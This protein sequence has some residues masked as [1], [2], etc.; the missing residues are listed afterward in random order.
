MDGLGP[1]SL[2]ELAFLRDA[3]WSPDG[4]RVAYVVSRT[5]G[6]AEV[7]E[8]W[9]AAADGGDARCVPAGGD[10]ATPR[11]SPDGRELAISAD[12]RLHIV[13]AATL[14]VSPPMTPADEQMTGAPS[15]SPDGTR[16]AVS[17][18][19]HAR[20]TSSQGIT[21]YDY[22]AEGLGL[23]GRLDRAI[24]EVRRSDGATRRLTAPELG[25]CS[26][27][28]WSPDGERVL[29]FATH[30]AVP[31]ASD[32]PRLLTVDIADGATTEVLAG[33]WFVTAARWLDG[34]RIVVIGEHASRLTIPYTRLWVV[35]RTGVDV[36][37][38]SSGVRGKF[39]MHVH[40]DMPAWDLTGEGLVVA[41]EHTAYATVQNG[42]SAEVW[43]IAL[44]G[45][46]DARPVLSGE[47]SCIVLD[48]R[49]GALLYAVT[50]LRTPPELRSSGPDGGNEH[51]L[52]GLNDAVLECWPEVSIDRMVFTSGDGL[53]IEG[54]RLAPR[55]DRPP[56]GVLFIHGGPFAATGHA[57][58]FDFLLLASHGLAVVFANFRGSAGYGEAH[59]RG[60]MGDWGANG[61][62]DHMA[63]ADAAVARGWVDP[64]RLGVW[65]ASHGG[66]ATCWMVTH[67]HRFR[68]AVA[69]AS[70]TDFASLYYLT[71]APRTFV[72]DLGG[73]PHEIPDVYRS[74]SP[75]SYAQSCRTPTM[76]IHGEA[77]LRCPIEQAEKFYRALLDARCEAELVRIPGCDH[78]GDS[79]GPL[80]AR[81]AQNEA[82]LRWF[83]ERL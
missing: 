16:L 42:G 66:F 45:D 47:R 35:D 8:V 26:G 56:P 68:A 69:E 32:S 2:F 48:V 18:S 81:L 72:A 19:R 9:T 3:R 43:R 82:L 80:S 6:D 58:R 73:R 38:R 70:V 17:L 67:T 22:R 61:F 29:F 39:G 13:D 36:R 54:W 63:T 5:R 4:T 41:D 10:A 30:D 52:T 55:S 7:R 24:H 15:W 60:I 59:V 71:D 57:F 53:E 31:F 23:L 50:D 44:D 14:A 78:R 28:E 79:T 62:P 64:D 11:W 40:H 83:V 25:L 75:L 34:E 33:D 21:A 49:H 20:P 27:P 76:L 37:L 77:D 74:R 12:A 46:T 1:E 65:G 51:R